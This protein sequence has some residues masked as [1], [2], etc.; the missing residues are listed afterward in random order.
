MIFKTIS[1]AVTLAVAGLSAQ[2][3]TMQAVFTGTVNFSLQPGN[4]PSNDGT[5]P[6][7][8]EF[9]GLGTSSPI[10]EAVSLTVIYDTELGTLI[11]ENDGTLSRQSL[12]GGPETTFS[13][14]SPII[15]ASIAI[16]GITL[17]INP[18]DQSTV[19]RLRDTG[20]GT[21]G[22]SVSGQSSVAEA[23]LNEVGDVRTRDVT[24]FQMSL[25]SRDVDAVPFD[26]DT[27]F[28]ATGFGSGS[29]LVVNSVSTLLDGGE[30]DTEYSEFLNI[31]FT[32]ESVTVTDISAVPLPAGLPLLL[33]GLGAFG[34]L[35]HR[36]V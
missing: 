29:L 6:P 3:A 18:T 9:F 5:L 2:A 4:D 33:A 30:I 21:S 12:F 23:E 15:S 36:K 27:P 24:A 10:G 22:A 31:F 32:T 16:N 17:A 11:P 7:I 26:F 35:R 20:S 13:E 19:Q 1:I 25:L 14:F 28:S 8:G 34:V